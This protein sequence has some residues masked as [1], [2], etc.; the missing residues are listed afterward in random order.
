MY[1]KR[2][3]RQ[4]GSA[5]NLFDSEV[6]Q[7][8]LRPKRDH[9]RHALAFHRG[10]LLDLAHVLEQLEHLLH[11]ALA[12][13]DVGQLAAAEQDVDQDLVLVFKEL[14]GLADLDP[15]VLSPVL[16]RTRISLTWTWCCFCFVLASSART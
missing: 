4:V 13:V 7:V 2:P 5:R 11:D 10:G 6:I 12:L 14:A 16:G 3:A 8:R 15:D 1:H 9:R